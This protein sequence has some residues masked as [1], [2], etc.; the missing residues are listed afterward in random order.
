[1]RIFLCILGTAILSCAC[2]STRDTVKDDSWMFKN[3]TRSDDYNPIME[4]DKKVDFKCPM[5]KK[6]VKWAKA[7]VFNPAALV[8]DN[9]V[10]LLFRAQD[11]EGTSRI[12]LAD[13]KDGYE[14]DSREKPVLYPDLDGQKP[15][16]WDGGCEDPRI[17]RD[18]NGRFVMTYTSY[19]K[20]TARLCVATSRDLVKWEKHGLAFPDFKYRNTW[21]KSGAIVCERQ[22]EKFVAKKIKGKYWMYWGDTDL[23][24]ATSEDLITWKPLEDKQGNL[25]RAM[26]PRPGMFDSRLVEPGPFALMR[27]GG[28]FLIYNSANSASNGDKTLGPD[29]YSVGQA[30]FSASRPERLIG[31][32]NQYLLTPQRYFEKEGSV[33]NVCFVEGLVWFKDHWWLYYGTGDSRIAVAECWDK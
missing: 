13:S 27:G 8:R 18:R 17:I 11:D 3:V 31:R 12:G 1:M 26:Q 21:S 22:G 30:L 6:Q 15:Y 9:R 25:V 29:V 4:P 32:A 5:R 16:E 2:N 19:D 33:A 14:F 23:F 10:W 20:K 7:N 28:I 24:V